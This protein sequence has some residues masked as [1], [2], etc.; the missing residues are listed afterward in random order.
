MRSSHPSLFKTGHIQI[1]QPLLAC[2]VLQ[3]PNQCGG[4]L[5]LF[6]LHSRDPDLGWKLRTPWDF[7]PG[8]GNGDWYSSSWRNSPL[9]QGC[10]QG[11]LG[12]LGVESSCLLLLEVSGRVFNPPKESS[13]RFGRCCMAGQHAGFQLTGS[14]DVRGGWWWA[15][16]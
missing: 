2:C 5:F 15:A 1:S 4:S 11:Q 13:A 8:K 9:C 12:L 3:P 14:G 16:S 6:L 10:C 7:I